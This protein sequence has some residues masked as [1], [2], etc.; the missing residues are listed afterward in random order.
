M[1]RELSEELAEVVF[2][3]TLHENL[4]VLAL[5]GIDAEFLHLSWLAKLKLSFRRRIDNTYLLRFVR[6]IDRISSPFEKKLLQRQID[7]VYFLSPSVWA[8]SLEILNYIATVWDLSHRDDPEF[9]EVRWNRE[10]ESR[11]RTYSKVLPRATAVFVDS[12]LGSKNV[13]R[14]YGVDQ[15]RIHVIPFQPALATRRASNLNSVVSISAKYNLE[16]PYV[17]YPA[18]FW[19]HKNHVYLLEGLKCLEG[20][21]GKR[22]GAI[23][24]G[25]DKGN[26][27]YVKGYVAKL[28]LED[29]VR[30]AGFV[31]N[32]EIPDL[33]LQSLALVM[34]SYFGPTNL[35]PLEAFR[36]GVPVLCSNKAGF[37]EQ[38]G[39]AALLM[40]L[41]NPDSLARHLNHLLDDESLRVRLIAAGIERSKYFEDYDRISPLRK[42]VQDF[43]WRRLTWQ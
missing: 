27:T 19:A 4:R 33:Y 41:A 21:Y 17:F 31:P 14:R 28:G 26:L 35:P 29:R 12:E 11:D 8:Q 18:Q 38:V 7:L 10:F 15:E 16:V 20:H 39:N 9:P 6:K 13:A 42:V 2:F 3:T 24:S 30:F 36:L 22:V 40:D 23:F 43:R 1:T 5:Y 25:G 34:P 32:G 37:R